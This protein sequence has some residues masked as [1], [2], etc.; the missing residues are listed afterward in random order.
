MLFSCDPCVVYGLRW[1][2]AKKGI[3]FLGYVY[4]VG[5]KHQQKKSK[6]AKIAGRQHDVAYGELPFA[7]ADTKAVHMLFHILA[8]CTNA[9]MREGWTMTK[10]T[11]QQTRRCLGRSWE[12][13]V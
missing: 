5:L 2:T 8:V 6:Q 9:H 10:R 4:A 1:E 3:I 7:H 13:P 11:S 12:G